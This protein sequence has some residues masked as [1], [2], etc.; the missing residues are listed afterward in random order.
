MD[1]WCNDSM[2]SSKLLGRG[3]IPLRSA[4]ISVNKIMVAAF[5]AIL[6]IILGITDGLMT[7]MIIQAGMGY[8][9]NPIM[10]LFINNDPFAFLLVKLFVAIG[11][12]WYVY[13]Y[14]DGRYKWCNRELILPLLCIPYMFI[15]GIQIAHLIS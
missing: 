1:R 13:H 6:L 15:V 3:S 5:F 11:F 7:I 4:N 2:S 10:G 14:G 8:E 12:T 9:L